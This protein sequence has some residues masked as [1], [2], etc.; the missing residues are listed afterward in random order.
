MNQL[1]IDV[2]LQKIAVLEYNKRHCN[3][4]AFTAIQRD[5]ELLKKS[6]WCLEQYHT[7]QPADAAKL[8]RPEWYL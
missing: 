1:A 3:T 5:I 8:F 7:T 2:L 6:I 4:H